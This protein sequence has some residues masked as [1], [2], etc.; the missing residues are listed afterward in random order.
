[1]PAKRIS[2][3]ALLV[4]QNASRFYFATIPVE[5]LFPYCFVAR[6]DEDP[7]TGFQ[8]ALNEA[9]SD[10]IAKY[11]ADGNGSIP[12]NIVLSA[13]DGAEFRYDRRNKSI[14]FTPGKG[15]FLVLDGQHRL[16]GY[17]KCRV[18]HRVPVAIY[19]D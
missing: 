5:A 19:Q 6:R 10:D 7:L 15:A 12:S 17:Q 13:Q 16:W 18:R 11:L 8:R 9:R 4:V 1:M 2:Y 14:S 3:P